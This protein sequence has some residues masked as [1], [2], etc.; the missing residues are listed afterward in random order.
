MAPTV[1]RLRTE[2]VEVRHHA[3]VPDTIDVYRPE[4]LERLARSSCHR[5]LR[6]Q[7]HGMWY[8]LCFSAGVPPNSR[9][10][11]VHAIN[12]D[13]AASTWSRRFDSA[14]QPQVRVC[15][16]PVTHWPVRLLHDRRTSSS[17]RTLCVTRVPWCCPDCGALCSRTLQPHACCPGTTCLSLGSVPAPP[18]CSHHLP[19]RLHRIHHCLCQLHPHPLSHL[20]LR[21][22]PCLQQRLTQPTHPRQRAPCKPLPHIRQQATCYGW[23]APCQLVS[24]LHKSL[25]VLILCCCHGPG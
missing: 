12:R 7:R 5:A 20:L 9:C 22:H 25:P 16:D 21:L 15:Q 14:S 11:G 17:N 18:P 6:N 2:L 23:L 8:D 4:G 1:Q 3:H 13:V 24:Q 10:W 19:S